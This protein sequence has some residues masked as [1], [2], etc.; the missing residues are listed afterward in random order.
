MTHYW[1]MSYSHR[2]NCFLQVTSLSPTKLIIISWL[3]PVKIY[4]QFLI[5]YSLKCNIL[6]WNLSEWYF[7][8]K[9]HKFDWKI[10]RSMCI[11]TSV[12][13]EISLF[14]T[15][16]VSFRRLWI[17]TFFVS[18]QSKTGLCSLLNFL[19]LPFA[20][21]YPDYLQLCIYRYFGS[22]ISKLAE[23]CVCV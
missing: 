13:R 19:M 16:S 15:V 4:L 17:L 20:I 6:K 21:V 2:N 3:L 18:S 11:T 7:S 1:E 14:C 5:L 12:V 10:N 23:V 8:C 22:F 9:C